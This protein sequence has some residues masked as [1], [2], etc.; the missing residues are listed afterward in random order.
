MRI[1]K[2]K[3]LF[4]LVVILL[5]S[6]IISGCKVF[7]SD[8]SIVSL[9][10]PRFLEASVG[11]I[12]FVAGNQLFTTDPLGFETL[13]FSSD[14]IT[15]KRLSLKPNLRQALFLTDTEEMYVINFEEKLPIPLS[16]YQS[17]KSFDYL[18]NNDIYLFLEDL[19]FPLNEA[20]NTEI[21]S[22][23]YPLDTIGENGI[24]FFAISTQY[25][26]AYAIKCST[27]YKLEL[28]VAS[29]PGNVKTFNSIN[30]IYQPKWAR[31]KSILIFST[32]QQMYMW[33]VVNAEAP[34]IVSEDAAAQYAINPNGTEVAI[35]MP[36]S[37]SIRI[38]NLTNHF[39]NRILS[40]SNESI[41]DIDWK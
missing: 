40:V 39:L 4:Q 17:V 23:D 15:K 11:T 10:D 20:L 3:Y 26:L 16:A 12:G 1:V 25:D 18:F 33:D 41:E 34:T 19:F 24:Q 22:I 32:N 6:S 29:M 8:P 2:I 5:L 37:S 30:P 14:T 35:I 28:K 13:K 27:N 9:S 38:I 31:D 21:P 36:G 7:N